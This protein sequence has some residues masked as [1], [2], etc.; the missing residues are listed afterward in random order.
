MKADIL[1]LKALFQKDVR[2][3]IP[4]FQRPYVWNQEDQWE[5]L[6]NDVRNIA[7]EY[8][9]QLEELGEHKQPLAE[10][11]AGSHFLG[12][13]VLQQQAT[14]SAELETRSVIDGQQR[15]TTLQLLLD[16]AQEV[17]ETDGFTKEAKQLRRLVL[18]DEDF[19]AADPDHVFKLW[20]TLVDQEAFRRAMAN[21]LVVDGYDAIPIVQ[22]HAFF[23]LQIRQWLEQQSD[24]AAARAG[25]LVVAMIGL[26]QM[27]VIDLD[28]TDDANIIFETLNAR[29]TPLLASD[30]IKNSIL[31]RADTIGLNSEALYKKHWQGFDEQWWRT[32]VRQGRITRP[33]IDTYLNYWLTMRTGEEVSSSDVFPRYRKYSEDRPV[34]DVVA[35]IAEVSQAYKTL[36]GFTDRS[37]VGVFLYRW[38]VMEAGVFTPALLW[39]FHN[40]NAIGDVD[41]EATIGALESYL[42]RRMICRMT[43]KDFNRLDIELVSQLNAGSPQQARAIVVDRLASETSPS[44]VW[45]GDEAVREAILGLPLYQLLTRGRLRMLLEAIEDSLRGPKTEEQFVQRGLTIEHIMPQGWRTH[46]HLPPDAAQDAAAARD[47]LVQSLGNLTLV[48]RALNPA[49]SNSAWAVKRPEIEEHS[50]LRLKSELLKMA[51]TDWNE[52]LI[53][54]RGASMADTIVSI[55]PRPK[56]TTDIAG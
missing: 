51:P 16:A 39:L 2:Y 37:R 21:E 15:L 19:A 7:E 43:T 27:V 42:V 22:A 9:E 6:W 55:W 1:T 56:P 8:L 40:R 4:T 14:G 44:R 5:P 41:F 29:G 23:Q 47:R 54:Q 52:E 10:Q 53:R 30:L 48:T 38:R 32:E 35:D 49:L 46:W 11:R 31:H 34:Q 25:A 36:E 24:G 45:P 20:P 33:R 18:N 13:V 3:V 28:P 50:A 12:A 26:L 17:F